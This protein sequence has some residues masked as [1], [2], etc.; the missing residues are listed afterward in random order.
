M[1]EVKSTISRHTWERSLRFIKLFVLSKDA[2]RRARWLFALLLVF[3]FGTNGLSV[4]NSYVNRA[5]MTAIANR[6]YAEFIR[7]G[8]LY[9]GVFAASTIVSVFYSFT[10]QRLGL[11]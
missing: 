8:L 3:M 6:A 1:E 5:F 7:M 9:I 4:V 11:V 2:G 10:E